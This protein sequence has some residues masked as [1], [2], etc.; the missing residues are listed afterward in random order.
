MAFEDIA[1][2]LAADLQKD[3]NLTRE[4]AVGLVGNLAME[5]NGFRTLQEKNPIVPGSRG[6]YGYAQWTGPR[7]KSF[8]LFAKKNDLDPASYEANYGFLKKEL[9]GSQRGFLAALKKAN[10]AA[11]ASTLTR[12][13]YLRPHPDYA[14]VPLR[15]SWV[16]KVDA[17]YTSPT[18]PNYT[19]PPLTALDAIKAATALDP[20]QIVSGYAGSLGPLTA[21]PVATPAPAPSA[22]SSVARNS[23]W[24]V[25]MYDA[26]VIQRDPPPLPMPL[27][28]KPLAQASVTL[29][30]SQLANVI[31]S[32]PQTQAF[33]DA[34][35][36][37]PSMLNLQRAAAD[38][39]MKN[40]DMVIDNALSQLP[41]SIAYDKATGRAVIADINAPDIQNL[42]RQSPE[43]SALLNQASITSV[44]RQGGTAL[45]AA[46]R[47]AGL[48]EPT[49]SALMGYVGSQ[50]PAVPRNVP[51]A[52]NILGNATFDAFGNIA[53]STAPQPTY[54]KGMEGRGLP[55]IG[56]GWEPITSVPYV[57]PRPA[58][59]TTPQVGFSTPGNVLP[60]TSGW[61]TPLSSAARSF[62]TIKVPNPAYQVYM[63]QLA[64]NQRMTPTGAVIG[65]DQMRAISDPNFR[66]QPIQLNGEPPPQ[67]LEK[68]VAP[69][70]VFNWT[71]S[72]RIPYAPPVP[73]T[74][75][76]SP[77]A[78]PA[79]G[80][81]LFGGI[82]PLGML[83]GFLAS[84]IKPP[85]VAPRG[86]FGQPLAVGGTYRDGAVW[87]NDGSGYGGSPGQSTSGLKTGERVYDANTNQ[88]GLKVGQPV[89]W[90][91]STSGNTS[92]ATGTFKG[93]STGNT[94]TVGKIYTNGNGS[95]Q[96]MPDGTFKRV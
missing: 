31:R 38:M 50:A 45:D 91:G 35:Y 85:S 37:K 66:T 77:T 72:S 1:T 68:R 48:G 49:P 23:P 10:D 46:N 88:W 3:F 67:F 15:D 78:A 53:S 14:H 82:A 2:R 69:P 57:T 44:P 9:M 16:S 81:G 64:A 32:L 59:P 47:L 56:A 20:T 27:T 58:Q 36:G 80:K 63:G 26:S 6:G 8:E 52:G 7:R 79:A 42:L 89:T 11:E 92:T 71:T 70:P 34:K 19:N 60:P 18:A 4:Q 54:Q 30:K 90:T 94:Y 93:T 25:P 73:Q 87:A 74:R 75:P 29:D 84:A 13:Q 43:A 24:L 65:A 12:K 96:A 21:K 33:L 95:Y 41:P 40:D 17:I 62:Q 61:D 39:A 55:P 22:A 51:A 76:Q 86:Q 28:S 83:S 5:S